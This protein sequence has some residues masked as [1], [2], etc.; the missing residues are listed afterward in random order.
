[1]PGWPWLYFQCNVCIIEF[2]EVLLKSQQIMCEGYYERLHN[3]FEVVF[4]QALFY[5]G[6]KKNLHELF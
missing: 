6:H 4:F 2:Y 3:T 1:M 5:N